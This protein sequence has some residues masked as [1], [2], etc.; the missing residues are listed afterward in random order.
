MTYHYRPHGVC[1][2]EIIVDLNEQGIIERVDFI[3][4]CPGNLIGIGKLVQGQKAEDVIHLLR[5]V[6]C[7]NKRTSCPDQLTY[8]LEE[9]L[10]NS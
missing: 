10:A 2:K 1:S 4:G 7:G 3:T 8:A 5:G 6:T 9:A